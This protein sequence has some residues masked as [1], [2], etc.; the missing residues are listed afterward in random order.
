[1]ELC[2]GDPFTYLA[3]GVNTSGPSVRL[4]ATREASANSPHTLLGL[5][6]R[7]LCQVSV[8]IPALQVR[9]WKLREE[10]GTALGHCPRESEVQEK[11]NKLILVF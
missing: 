11:Q 9:T 7:M 1:M 4:P 5:H 8:F 2:N 3:L 6:L 10:A